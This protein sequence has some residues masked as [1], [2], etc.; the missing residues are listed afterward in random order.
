MAIHYV[1]MTIHNV[2]FSIAFDEFM[3]SFVGRA[4]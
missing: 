4:S 3:V 1:E 2:T